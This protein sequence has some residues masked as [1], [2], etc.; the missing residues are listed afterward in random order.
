MAYK[1]PDKDKDEIVDYSIDWS[2]FLDGD[3]VASVQ[4]YIQSSEGVN[5][6][7]TNAGVVDNLQFVA[8]TNTTTVTTARFSL[9]NNNTRYSIVC[10]IGTAQGLRYE[11]TVS[12]RIKEK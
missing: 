1:W 11:R 12:L 3:T 6:P 2:R 9:G 5:V 4:W 10:R 7:V 8:G